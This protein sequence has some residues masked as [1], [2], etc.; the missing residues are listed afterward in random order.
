MKEKIKKMFS[1][2]KNII[3]ITIIIGAIALVIGWKYIG[4]APVVNIGESTNPSIELTSQDNV[5]LSFPKSGRLESV[6]VKVGQNV[7]KGD[8]LAKLSAPDSQGAVSQAKSAL[9][10]AE[11]QYALLNT[12]YKTT[13]AQ[14][15][16]IVENA[17]K[18]LLS[19]GLEGTPNKQ[20][21]NVP[22]ISGTYT[23]GKEGSYKIEPYRSSDND[24]GYSFKYSGL[25]SGFAPVKY[26]N[27]IALGD[28]GLQ[29]KFNKVSEYFNDTI[30]WTIEIPNKKS[31]VYMANKNSYE[32]ALANREKILTDLS[33]NIG[34]SGN[35]N[36][37]ARAQVEAAR[38]SY[39]AALGS[40]QN[41]L[42]IAPADGV[43]TSIDENLK[44]GQ[45]VSSN[46]P[47][48]SITIK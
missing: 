1:K 26:E 33:T 12:Q 4:K 39:E 19:S 7:T 47:V 42:I 9:D 15:D 18:T 38:G 32:L 41:N 16:L 14:Q 2:P 36:S 21:L 5:D 34:D 6:L 3:F 8:I 22:T 31:S 35:E 23:C 17:Y 46:K 11:A 48:I 27:P 43:V 25:E 29:I 40:Y 10:L 13:K 30:T 20:D 37:V 28:C 45:S 24:T 44:V